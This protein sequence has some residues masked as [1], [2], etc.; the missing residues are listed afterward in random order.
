MIVTIAS[1][2]IEAM[3]RHARAE[4]PREACGLLLGMPRVIAAAEPSR[5]V[6]SHPHRTFEIEPATLLRAYREA[7]GA[8][9]EVLGWYHSHPNGVAQPS[10]TDAAR[11][12]E[13]GKLWLIVTA[14]ALSAWVAAS[15]GAAP[16]DG[17]VA[18]P[19]H[20]RFLPVA[21]RVA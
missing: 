9:R 3:Q 15:D 8:G 18:A 17:G 13:D 20:D 21:L 16:R 19:L 1:G 4:H 10:A 11:A 7:R 12:V 14:D 6:A 2:V 5:N